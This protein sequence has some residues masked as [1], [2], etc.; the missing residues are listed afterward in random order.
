MADVPPLVHITGVAVI[1]D[2]ELRLTFEDGTVGDVAF[3]ADEWRGVFQPLRDPAVFS[4]VSVDGELRTVGWA[5]GPDMAPE[6]LY[7]EAR[8][9]AVT[10]RSRR[11]RPGTRSARAA[12]V[13][14]SPSWRG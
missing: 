11:W 14:R 4:Q 13:S 7:E 8:R 1:G 6:P 10:A 3:A 12:A 9:N 5:R 2:D